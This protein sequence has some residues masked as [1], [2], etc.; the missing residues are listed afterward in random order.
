MVPKIYANG[1]SVVVQSNDLALL[2]GLA[3]APTG[4]VSLPYSVAK[5]LARQLSD[6]ITG[7]ESSTTANVL[8]AE[9]LDKKL[10]EGNVK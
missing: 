6:A 10:K 1:F 9:F 5:A 3:G 4:I 2:L 8:D 7:Y